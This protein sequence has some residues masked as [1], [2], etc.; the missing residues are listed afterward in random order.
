MLQTTKF[1]LQNIRIKLVI[2]EYKH[3]PL[4]LCFKLLKELDEQ[5]QL[6]ATTITNKGIKKKTNSTNT[7]YIT[8]INTYHLRS[9]FLT[10]IV[11]TIHLVI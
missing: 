7:N 11:G 8:P 6:K 10:P 1:I 5:K 3:P 2:K 9:K 4:T